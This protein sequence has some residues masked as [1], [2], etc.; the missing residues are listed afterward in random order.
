[1]D[2]KF[3]GM[4]NRAPY[5]HVYGKSIDFSQINASNKEELINKQFYVTCSQNCRQEADPP[6]CR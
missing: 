1:M 4:G 3:Y 2:D 5:Q 6:V